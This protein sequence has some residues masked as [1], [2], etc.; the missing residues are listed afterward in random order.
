MSMSNYCRRSV[1]LFRRQVD[2]QRLP[3]TV[4][5][6]LQSQTSRN[7]AI[8]FENCLSTPLKFFAT[9]S[10]SKD[11]A[12]TYGE[13]DL[14]VDEPA[15]PATS[16]ATMKFYKDGQLVQGKCDSEAE[17]NAQAQEDEM[18]NMFVQGPMG[19]EWNGPT[20]GGKRPEPTRFGDWERKGRASDF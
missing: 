19:M 2:P 16:P 8:S 7:M 5:A 15:T 11:A 20:R 4:K 18:E 17:A 14:T 12:T 3:A 13:E 1:L 10:K 9:S 6:R